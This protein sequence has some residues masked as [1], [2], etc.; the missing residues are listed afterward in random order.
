VRIYVCSTR[1]PLKCLVR[2]M[3]ERRMRD[4]MDFI[5]AQPGRERFGVSLSPFC[6]LSIEAW[7]ASPRIPI[8]KRTTGLKRL[9][10]S[11]YEAQAVYL[12]YNV[13]TSRKAS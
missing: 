8:V 5:R 13:A 10:K 9:G 2:S 1:A 6:R 11:G 7:G 4:V 12:W 3:S